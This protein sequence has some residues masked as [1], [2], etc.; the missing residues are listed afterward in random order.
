MCRLQKTEVICDENAMNV[1]CSACVQKC[2][3]SNVNMTAFLKSLKGKTKR[4]Y[5]RKP[6]TLKKHKTTKKRKS[7]SK[8]NKTKKS[9]K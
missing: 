1:I 6:T 4:K 7:T 3:Q 5:V 8:K 9:K 2:L